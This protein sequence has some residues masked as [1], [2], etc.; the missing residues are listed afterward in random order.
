M[1]LASHTFK[2]VRRESM[3]IGNDAL[4]GFAS[5]NSTVNRAG[6]GPLMT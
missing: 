4:L 6:R 1:D 3:S 5:S 2:G